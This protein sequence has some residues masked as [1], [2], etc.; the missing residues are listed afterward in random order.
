MWA[1]YHNAKICRKFWS[2]GKTLKQVV[3]FV[4]NL[5]RTQVWASEKYALAQ[6]DA[7]VANSSALS[8][9]VDDSR[10]RE[11]EG[12]WGV[13]DHALRIRK[14]EWEI[15]GDKVVFMVLWE[16][17]GVFFISGLRALSA[18]GCTA[19]TALQSDGRRRRRSQ[20]K[21]YQSR[22]DKPWSNYVYKATAM[23]DHCRYPLR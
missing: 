8:E 7:A 22:K 14:S 17:E 6:T 18:R 13:F 23:T 20:P 19:V 16:E 4:P 3:A 9:R 15:A 10:G 2:R 11:R 5:W 1:Q 12:G 21:Y